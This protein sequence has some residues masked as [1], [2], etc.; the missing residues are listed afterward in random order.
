MSLF[1]KTIKKDLK[2]EKENKSA[3]YNIIAD[4]FKTRM[5]GLDQ[6]LICSSVKALNE[7]ITPENQ[8]PRTVSGGITLIWGSNGSGKT[9]FCLDL[10]FNASKQGLN[11]LYV[12]TEDGIDV[13]RILQLSKAFNI[14]KIDYN[15]KERELYIDN[16]TVKQ[17]IW[18]NELEGRFLVYLQSLYK[19]NKAPK[20]LIIDNIASDYVALSNANVDLAMYGQQAKR[21]AVLSTQI[22]NWALEWEMAVVFVT[23][24][25]SAVGK[26]QIILEENL[27]ISK[28]ILEEGIA[29]DSTDKDLY[30]GGKQLG[31]DAK[32]QLEFRKKSRGIREVVLFKHRSKPV[33]LS[34]KFK[35][36][37]NGIEDI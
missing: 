4:F 16:I 2:D 35:I 7:M 3:D 19:Q 20:L 25:I 29:P 5:T 23:Y 30:V 9:N 32:V 12:K 22:K 21:M 31:F 26:A 15:E 13:A 37:D 34:A 18:L 36:T 1:K 33:G 28:K 24:P 14:K 27:K 11:V 10:A 8:Q 6:P 17:V